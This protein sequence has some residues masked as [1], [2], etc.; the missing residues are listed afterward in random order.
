MVKM[1]HWLFISAVAL[2]LSSTLCA[3]SI[4]THK[5]VPTPQFVN[6]IGLPVYPGAKPMIG[7]DIGETSRLGGADT[8]SAMFMTHDDITKVDAFYSQHVP[9]VA[10]KTVIPMGFTTT[11]TY[12]WYATDSQK[13][14]IFNHVKDVTVIQLQ[15][16]KLNLAAPSST[17][18]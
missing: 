14:I 13:Q 9:K 12:Q 18:S 6:R 8:L 4:Q 11:T 15:S 3:C 17:P 10:R 16:M 7:Q 1:P 2:T 5:V